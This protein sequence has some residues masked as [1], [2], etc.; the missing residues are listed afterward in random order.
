VR[1]AYTD[2]REI[3]HAMD[4]GALVVVVPRHAFPKPRTGLSV[5]LAPGSRIMKSM[6]KER[7]RPPDSTRSREQERGKDVVQF[8]SEV[9]QKVR[10]AEIRG[11]AI[12]KKSSGKGTAKGV[13]VPVSAEA[14]LGMTVE[15]IIERV[16]EAIGDREQ[17]M[18]WLGTP[19]RAL[20]FA[21]P[22]SMLATT[23]G[24]RR[25]LDVL[26]QMEHGVW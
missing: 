15:P 17:A 9:I 4:L 10:D 23:S 5:P 25:V 8:K 1:V 7:S 26:G 24:K 2:E 20:D 3:Q 16:V 21:T 18:R 19:V 6:E 13:W 14:K 11:Q 12:E 22:I